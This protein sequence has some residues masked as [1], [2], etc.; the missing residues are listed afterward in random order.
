[1]IRNEL[2]IGRKLGLAF[3]AT[4]LVSAI[5]ICFSIFGARTTGQDTQVLAMS[6]K[7]LQLQG[8]L[9]A[10]VANLRTS[11][12][13]VIMYTSAH[14]ADK[15]E[16]NKAA[17]QTSLDRIHELLGNIRPL[18]DTPQGIQDLEAIGPA[19]EQYAAAFIKIA[20]Q[21]QQGD[22]AGAL[23]TAAQVGTQGNTLQARAAELAELERK[24]SAEATARVN[25][26]QSKLS[27]MSFAVAFLMFGILAVS[28][29]LVRRISRVLST[30]VGEMGQAAEQVASAAGQI[31]S[32]SQSLAQGS[33]EQAASLVQTS[34]SSEEINSM[35]GKNSE[36]S[37]TAAALVTSSQQKFTETNGALQGMVV[38]MGEINA[39]SDKISKIIRTIDEIAF[40]TNIL[41]LNAAV[42]AARAGEAGMGF[43]VV[44]DEVRNLA[45][46]SAQAAKDTAMLIEESIAKS[47]GG[48]T[49]VDQVA[50]AIQVITD[51]ATRIRT[52]VD[53][54]HLGSQEQAQGIEQI[55][56]AIAQMEQ[57]TQKTAANAEESASAAEELN[58]QSE[59]M[60]D[61]VERLSAMVGR[62]N[63]AADGGPRHRVRPGHSSHTGLAALQKAVSNDP[64]ALAAHSLVPVGKAG[65]D[66]YSIPLD[67]K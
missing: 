48:K 45:Q 12:R 44:A 9:K 62:G 14:L 67:D 5:L 51:E 1:M 6:S 34:S 40:Q 55:A 32:S 22:T 61:I 54:V 49:K 41:A 64:K 3:G 17:F 28:G 21:C 58:A 60:R 4:G 39:Q 15:V 52:L 26:T 43:A 59:A 65:F 16:Q 13:G 57:V 53:E 33:A 37:R 27:M 18:V 36:N 46:R 56:K 2:T 50:S 29:V 19:L 63:A 7:K 35:A 66:R 31:A 8:E 20:N 24:S 23:E 30:L 25:D 38:A 11:Q 42:E 10:E 47:A